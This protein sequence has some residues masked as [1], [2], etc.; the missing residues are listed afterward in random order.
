M[1]NYLLIPLVSWAAVAVIM[2]LTK[3]ALDAQVDAVREE[4]K[5]LRDELAETKKDLAAIQAQF[6]AWRSESSLSATQISRICAMSIGEVY[7]TQML[8]ERA[9]RADD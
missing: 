1:S 5:G 2:I 9:G 7:D 3:V 8:R 6:N 4:G